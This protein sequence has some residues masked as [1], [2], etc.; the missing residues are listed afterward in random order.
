MPQ[1]GELERA[2]PQ[3]APTSGGWNS[4]WRDPCERESQVASVVPP[5]LSCWGFPVSVE[6]PSLHVS[7]PLVSPHHPKEGSV[8]RF[9]F[10]AAL[11]V[12]SDEISRLSDWYG[13]SGTKSR[14]EVAPDEGKA[15]RQAGSSP[16]LTRS[17]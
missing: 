6:A 11:R 16:R 5:L 12:F 7:T 15:A 17:S 9:S 13:A 8:W 2:E 4:R 3:T 14:Y 1:Q 10:A